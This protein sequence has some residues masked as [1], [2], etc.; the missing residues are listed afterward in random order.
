M[1]RLEHYGKT[2][3]VPVLRGCTMY[4]PLLPYIKY[5]AACILSS[6]LRVALGANAA[7]IVD[8]GLLRSH[9]TELVH[10]QDKECQEMIQ[11][12]IPSS[13][14]HVCCEGMCCLCH[15]FMCNGQRD[16]GGHKLMRSLIDHL[17]SRSHAALLRLSSSS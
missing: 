1:E 17:S 3:S 10:V 16:G 6:I 12:W 8:E 13:G 5:S 11:G 9:R 15:A 4:T 14:K 7:F 2:S